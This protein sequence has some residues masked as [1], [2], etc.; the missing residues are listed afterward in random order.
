MKTLTMMNFI[1][2]KTNMQKVLN[3]VLIV[4]RRWSAKNA[5][6]RSS[7]YLVHGIAAKLV[8]NWE[9]NMLYNESYQDFCRK[10][11]AILTGLKVSSLTCKC[12]FY[13][14]EHNAKGGGTPWKWTLKALKCRNETY[15]RIEFK[16]K[17]E[18]MGSFV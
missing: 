9:Q 11:M 6:K 16:E 14:P 2:W 7:K 15:Q 18:K 1:N 13:R 10:T 17:M 3:L 5:P 4:D 8:S 12:L